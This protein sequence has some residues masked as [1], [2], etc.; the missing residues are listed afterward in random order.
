MKIVIIALIFTV[1]VGCGKINPNVEVGQVYTYESPDPF[2]QDLSSE[3][4]IIEIKSGYVQ[5]STYWTTRNKQGGK[6]SC[7]L[8]SVKHSIRS[9]RLKLKSTKGK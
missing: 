6:H 2:R 4:T 8:S 9:G 7:S 1:F 3:D 5:Y